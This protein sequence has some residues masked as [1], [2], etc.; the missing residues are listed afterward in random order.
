MAGSTPAGQQR[1]GVAAWLAPTLHGYD[2]SWLRPD[3]IAGIA[4]GAVVLPQAMAYATIAGVP[5]EIGLYTC[6]LPLV[7]YALLGGSRTLSVSTTSTVAVLVAV[8]LA[9]AGGIDALPT[10]VLMVG[11]ILLVGALLH[12]GSVVENISGA[13]LTGVKAGVGLTVSVAQ[14]PK[15]LGVEPADSS[16]GFFVSLAH[17][18]E[19]LPDLDPAT[20]VLGVVSVL[21]FVVLSKTVPAVPAPLV[22][23]ALGI[24]VVAVGGDAV[25]SITQVPPVPEGVPAPD[26]PP[27]DHLAALFPGALAISLMVFLETVSVGTA[28]RAR[29]DPPIDSNRELIAAGSANLVGAFTHAL[30]SAGG[31]SQT[32]VNARAGARSQLSGLTTGVLAVAVALFLGPVLDLMPDTT[33]AALVIVATLSLVKPAEFARLA[34]IDRME[35]WLASGIAVVA[36]VVGL[37]AGVL[38]GVL[39]TWFLVLRE[40]NSAH[41]EPV[42]HPDASRHGMLVLRSVTGLYTGNVQPTMRAVLALVAEQPPPSGVVL[43]DLG[44]VRRLSVTVLDALREM[45]HTLAENGTTLVVCGLWPSALDTA[46]RTT[47]WASWEAEGRVAES[48]DAAV[49]AAQGP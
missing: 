43:L 36:L 2:R 30:P 21:L 20:A 28:M 9:S 49:A 17:V 19:E 29:T 11:A 25:D 1:R 8:T 42:A 6:M 32:A 40:L 14:L 24:V 7:T 39:F 22:V 23:V 27:L 31:F 34:R 33:L 12:I 41:V 48:V 26:L 47:W 3:L 37:L 45:D 13:V 15:L 5:V 10:L 46:R 4:C 35:F 16:D 18:V 44:D 38:A